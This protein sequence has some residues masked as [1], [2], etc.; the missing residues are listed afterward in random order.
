MGKFVSADKAI[1]KNRFLEETFKVKWV[2]CFLETCYDNILKEIDRYRCVE[3]SLIF[4][5]LLSPDQIEFL[6]IT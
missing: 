6:I 2:N 4:S 5:L 1:K 3:L